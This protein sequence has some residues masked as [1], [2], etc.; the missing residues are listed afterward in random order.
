MR[1]NHPNFR[2]SVI[3]VG[4][5]IYMVG[6][7]FH[8]QYQTNRKSFYELIS[9]VVGMFYLPVLRDFRIDIRSHRDWY[10]ALVEKQYEM[11]IVN[12]QIKPF[13]AISHVFDTLI[14][15]SQRKSQKQLWQKV[16]KF[17]A[18]H[19]SRIRVETQLINGE[20]TLVWKWIVPVNLINP[21]SSFTAA[22]ASMPIKASGVSPKI[23]SPAP[24]T[25]FPSDFQTQQ[26]SDQSQEPSTTSTNSWQG[27]AFVK[28]DKIMMSPTPC[29]KI[30]NMFDT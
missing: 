6:K 28:P 4:A 24:T 15:H 7:L 1:E 9:Q 13:V 29:L 22:I 14:D 8:K 5:L 2:F 3:I 16:V 23:A 19:E 17:I 27:S 21:Q 18:D 20:E 12:Q 11:S 30:R 10:L 26:A 25:L